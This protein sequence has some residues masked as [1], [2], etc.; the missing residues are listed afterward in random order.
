MWFCVGFWI[1]FLLSVLLIRVLF[2][3]S[4]VLILVNLLEMLFVLVLFFVFFCKVMDGVGCV[5][6][7]VLFFCD[8]LCR[9]VRLVL[10]SVYLGLWLVIWW[11]LCRMEC[12]MVSL[13]VGVWVLWWVLCSI[14]FLICISLLLIYMEV[15][16]FVKF[17]FFRKLFWMVDWEM[18]LFSWVSVLV[19][20]Y[21]GLNRVGKLICFRL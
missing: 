4:S 6:R 19:V 3:L 9:W 20:W 15:I 13:C 17:C 12:V 10:F 21:V 18:Y 5:V 16:V 7:V 14:R 8:L 11:W 1:G 2:W